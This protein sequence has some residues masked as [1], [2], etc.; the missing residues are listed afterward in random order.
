[1]NCCR[2]HKQHRA[3]NDGARGLARGARMTGQRSALKGHYSCKITS[4]MP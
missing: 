3:H 4:S 2:T 1:M